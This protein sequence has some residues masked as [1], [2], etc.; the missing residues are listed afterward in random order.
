MIQ[1]EGLYELTLDLDRMP[2]KQLL[3]LMRDAKTKAMRALS[4]YSEWNYLRVK[5]R[6]E[7]NR[8]ENNDTT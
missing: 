2:D 3:H 1:N 7:L 6:A 5:V 8:R 4:R